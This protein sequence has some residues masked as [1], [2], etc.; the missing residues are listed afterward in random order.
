M[1]SLPTVVYTRVHKTVDTCN[2]HSGTQGRGHVQHTLEYTRPWTRAAYMLVVMNNVLICATA[3]TSMAFS[4]FHLF[5]FLHTTCIRTAVLVVCMLVCN[6][7][8]NVAIF[9]QKTNLLSHGNTSLLAQCSCSTTG[10]VQQCSLH[11]PGG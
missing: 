2:I 8:Y 1:R 9:L 6:H 4:A 10:A 3:L 5:L 11:A 7:D